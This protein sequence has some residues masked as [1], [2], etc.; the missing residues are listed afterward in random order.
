MSLFSIPGV[1]E[2]EC[3]LLAL[4]SIGRGPSCSFAWIVFPGFKS[5][6]VTVPQAALVKLPPPRAQLISLP[7]WKVGET[8]PVSMPYNLGVLVSRVPRA[9]TISR[10]VAFGRQ[11]TGRHV[12]CQ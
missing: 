10:H 12:G 6:F 3:P 4:W 11:P 5:D 9:T 7:E 1:Y 8:R 2:N